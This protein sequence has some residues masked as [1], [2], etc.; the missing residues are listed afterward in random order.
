MRDYPVE[1]WMRDAKQLSLCVMTASQADQLA[2]ALELGR[3]LDP[4]QILPTAETQP[5]FV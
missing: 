3:P 4:G 2:A 1:K 5:T